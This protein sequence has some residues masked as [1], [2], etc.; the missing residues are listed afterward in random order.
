MLAY[1]YEPKQFSP[2]ST[3]EGKQLFHNAVFFFNMAHLFSS[4]VC[5]CF[6]FLS[7]SYFLSLYTFVCF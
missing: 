4:R 6:C 5:F 7:N 1:V 2:S 3:Y